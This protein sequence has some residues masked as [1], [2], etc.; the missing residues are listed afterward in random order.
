MNRRQQGRDVLVLPM[1]FVDGSLMVSTDGYVSEVEIE[2][3]SSS[4]NLAAGG[5]NQ[6]VSKP[7]IRDSQLQLPSG[8]CVKPENSSLICAAVQV[9]NV[10]EV[11]ALLEHFETKC[12]ISDSVNCNLLRLSFKDPGHDELSSM[13]SKMSFKNRDE[14]STQVGGEPSVIKDSSLSRAVMNKRQQGR[15]VLILPTKFVDGSLMG[16]TA[17]YTSEF[18]NLAAGDLNQPVSKPLIRDSQL[19]LPSGRCVESE[20]KEYSSLICADDQVVNVV[21]AGECLKS[22]RTKLGKVYVLVC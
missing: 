21:K 10:G 1:K 2:T 7:L 20:I 17:G 19:Q 15:D 6:Q 12:K 8:G 9:V 14:A 18:D 5:L 13:F 22:K 16:S 11:D 4:G 3:S